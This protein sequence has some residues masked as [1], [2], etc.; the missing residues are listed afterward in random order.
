MSEAEP[1]LE[2]QGNLWLSIAGQSVG[3]RGRFALLGLI[4]ACGS[5]SQ[6]AKRMGMTYKNAWDAVDAMNTA[7]GEPL[8]ARSVGGRGGGGA[9]LTGRGHQLIARFEEVERAHRTFLQS[10]QA[11][12]G[13]D[14]DL[15]LIRRIGMITSARNQFHGRVS[16]LATGAV[17]DEVQI[18]VA[19][20]LAL[21]A[22]ITHGS[23][24][25]LGLAVG[26]PAY[27]LVKASSVIVAQGEDARYSTRNQFAGTVERITE[28]AVNDEVVVDIGHGCSVV[29]VITCGS[30]AAL[31]LRE[32]S[33]ATVLFKASSVIVGVP[34]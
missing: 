18:E 28:G 33:T 5:I 1:P 11:T 25:S 31:E 20:G 2:L 9:R 23:V 24:E 13:L 10:L 16:A 30:T 27:A 3:G 19:P 32:G 4:D 7:A 22:T 6:A 12:P 34:M 8:V 29:A 26:V 15:A 21:V 14:E 17:N